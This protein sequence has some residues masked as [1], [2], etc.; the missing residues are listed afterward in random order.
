MLYAADK[1]KI[2]GVGGI[3]LKDA[4]PKRPKLWIR[5]PNLLKL[6]LLL[7]GALV[8]DITNGFDQTMLNSKCEQQRIRSLFTQIF[9][10]H[11]GD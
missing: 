4:I 5:Y 7:L 10:R 6:N 9:I 11:L 2:H 3:V 8:C 1:E